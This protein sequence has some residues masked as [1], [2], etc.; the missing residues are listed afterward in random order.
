MKERFQ[1]SQRRPPTRTGSR[2][3]AGQFERV[4]FH[5]TLERER[6]FVR[7]GSAREEGPSDSANGAEFAP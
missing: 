3:S 1:Q 7:L 2:R 4:R 5:A 6:R